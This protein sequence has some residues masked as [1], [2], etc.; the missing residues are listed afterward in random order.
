MATPRAR[1]MGDH[2]R[3]IFATQPLLTLPISAKEALN[4]KKVRRKTSRDEKWI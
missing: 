2:N 4:Q 3:A 1:F